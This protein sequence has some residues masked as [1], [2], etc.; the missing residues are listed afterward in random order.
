[1]ANLTSK[2]PYTGEINATFET[3][4]DT[5]LTAKIEKA[6]KAQQAWKQTSWDERNKLFHKLA[7]VIEADLDKYAE[8]QTIEMGMLYSASKSGLKSTV[9]LIRW[10]ADNVEKYLG[11]TDFEEN[12]TVGKYKYDPLGVIYGIGPWN[13]PYNQV[14]RA[15]VPNI[16]AGNTTVYK[17]ASNVPM[18]AEQIEKFFLDAGFP[19]G[20]Y[21]NIFISSSQSEHIIQNPYIQ[22]VNLTGSEDA[23]S[24]VGGLAGKY[25]K[26][27][28]LE[29]G[30]NDAFVLADH[31]DT[32][33]MAAEATAYRISNGGQK[34]NSS[35]RFIIMEKHY[36]VFVDEM[37]K[38]METMTLGDPMQASTNIPP[39]SSE[40]L[41]KD[42][43]TQVQKTIF[44]GARLVCGGKI[45]GDKNQFYEGTVLA[46]VTS[47]MTS[48]KEEVFG[49]VA[50]IIKSKD[51]EDSIRI[52][53]DSDFGLSAVVYGDDI[54]Q[55][56]D[57]ANKLE[58]GMIFINA[59]AGSKSHLP[60]GGVKKSGYGK[61]NGPEGLRAF[62]NKKAI[63]Y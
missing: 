28:V 34:C 26:Q 42:I 13:F 25:L 47:E 17:H 59:P 45:S 39:M 38:Y 27:S 12:G 19:E 40:K 30:G 43:D 10:F 8:L 32:V 3:L 41:L 58:G 29:L 50:S 55:C 15:A 33:K 35:K 54:E 2:N 1:M 46:D 7:D 53:N 56:K 22:G 6:H 51:L 57:V 37:K 62:T 52:A 24:V 48:Y 23:G 11:D 14:L 49:P 60:F 61:E 9:S 63:I 5:Q 44:E 4:T 36:D 16:L 21:Q 18:C 31:E 20:I